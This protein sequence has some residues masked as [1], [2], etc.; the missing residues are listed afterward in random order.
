[1]VLSDDLYLEARKALE[2]SI[3]YYHGNPVGTVAA[4]VSQ[5][6]ALN[7]SHCFVRDFAVS[8][9]AFLMNGQLEIVRNFLVETLKLQSCDKV[10]DCF[11]PGQGLMPASF[12][13]SNID[14]TETVK[15]DFGEMA[16]ARVAP[17]DSGFWWLLILR[18]YV[19]ASGD[20]SLARSAEFQKGIKLILDLCLTNRFDM[21]PTLLVPDGSFMI[22]RRMGVHGY[23]LDIQALF[24]ASLRAAK[25]LLEPGDIYINLAEERSGHLGYHIRKYY[26]LNYQHLNEIYRYKVE[27]F[28]E[29]VVNNF[30]I[31]PESIPEWLNV[32]L[33]DKGGYFIGNLGAGWMDFRFFSQGNL[34]A[35][36]SGLASSEQSLQI[37]DLIEQK[38]DTLIGQM[39]LKVCFP[40][41]EGR[42]WHII[43]GCDAK[44]IPWSY[45]NSGNWPFLLWLLAAAAQKTGRNELAERAI[46]LAASRL[47]KDK[48]PEYYD[49]LHGRLIGK[50]AR[51]FQTWTIA[52]LIAAE[53]LV[54]D[55]K[56]LDLIC[57]K[58]D[59]VIPAC[60]ISP[61]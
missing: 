45:H 48:Y 17:V 8:A 16:I 53:D 2:K 50:E 11:K 10:M 24:F 59:L 3:I 21:F 57:F 25:E 55:A 33:P 34:L 1:M 9:M 54:S 27:E 40:A 41:L 32:W 46:S 12:L 39:P 52:G 49:G 31:Y 35:I 6:H 7:Y 30:N 20:L 13:I 5:K 36:I 43:T 47:H 37:M 4:C 29:T 23:P 42:D 38:W 44:N 51:L 61:S 60:E 22:D 58:D 28:G 18:A 19:R 56:N 26:W 14:G 15:P